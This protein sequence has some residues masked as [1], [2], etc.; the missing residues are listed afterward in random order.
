MPFLSLLVS[1]ILHDISVSFI[2]RATG[3]IG[4]RHVSVTQ[5]TQ[6]VPT[7]TCDKGHSPHLR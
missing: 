4:L 6:H 5:S 3:Y 2:L 1:S 7:Q